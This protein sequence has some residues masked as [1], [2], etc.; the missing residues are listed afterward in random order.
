MRIILIITLMMFVVAPISA[1]ADDDHMLIAKTIQKYFDG[2]TNGDADLVSEAFAESLEVQGMREGDILRLTV[3]DYLQI[4]K[5]GRTKGRV[6]R[7]ISVDVSKNAAM[8][9]AEI[10]MG[11]RTLIDYFLL[12]KTADGWKISNKIFAEITPK[13]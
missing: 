10:K 11:E 13:K 4:V 1:S 5:E 7:L 9:K 8:A 2:A 3:P 12:L 6:S